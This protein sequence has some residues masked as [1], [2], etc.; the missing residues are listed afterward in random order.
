MLHPVAPHY[1][2]LL[3]FDP[4]EYPKIVGDVAERW[5]ISREMSSAVR[6]AVP[7]KSICSRRWAIPRSSLRSS[8]A[9][10][11]KR[12][13][14]LKGLDERLRAE[15]ILADR[16]YGD[17]T[18]SAL[19]VWH[20]GKPHL[21]DPGYLIV[22]PLPLPSAAGLQQLINCRRAHVGTPRRRP[23]PRCTPMAPPPT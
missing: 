2:T 3:R 17:D 5:S 8:T 11:L 12:R 6:R 4:H 10:T 20:E 22:R 19:V 21:L 18:H 13:E 7:L 1:S 23:S 15:P 14:I 9:P 16:R